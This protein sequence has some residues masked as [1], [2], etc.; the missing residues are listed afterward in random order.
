MKRSGYNELKQRGIPG[1][2]IQLYEVNG[3]HPQYIMP[4]HW[5]KEIEFVFIHSGQLE[6]FINN[7]PF[8][9]K[10]GD[11]AFINC[12]HLHR[13]EPHNCHYECIVC[14]LNM[15]VKNN[16]E[17]CS[18]AYI[19]PI[20]LSDLTVEPILN[21]DQSHLYHSVAKL[22]E[23]M[24]RRSPFY[25]LATMSALFDVFEKLYC[26]NRIV[27]PTQTDKRIDQSR[28]IADMVMW[29]DRNYTE[30]ITLDMLSKQT[31]LT[32]NY[33][34]RVFK[35]YTGKSPIEYVNGVRIKNVCYDIKWGQKNITEAAL[36]NG[37]DDISYFCK[38]FKRHTGMSA[39]EYKRKATV[40]SPL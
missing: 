6:L 8:Y 16:N 32:P 24:R 26:C 27:R 22:F 10:E 12:K 14:D 31:G 5:H 40:K 39:K 35:E 11:I 25:E 18:S 7:Q 37:Y 36:D 23:T 2:P 15:L 21:P 20:I 30:R 33:I 17:L 29:I 3:N 1:F 13:G 9:L 19:N 4:L 38:V 28:R 34:C